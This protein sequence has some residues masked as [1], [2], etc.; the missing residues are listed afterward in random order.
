MSTQKR[1]T[2]RL[3]REKTG[4]KAPQQ[5]LD[6]RRSQ[7]DVYAKISAALKAGP[8][9]VPEIAQETGLGTKT[10]F[11]YVSTYYKYNLIYVAG[12]TDEGYYRY[13]AKAK[14]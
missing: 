6:L 2:S 14:E 12:K 1:F 13:G 7:L 8:K 9:T 4:A 10:V 3:Y 5:L 11:W